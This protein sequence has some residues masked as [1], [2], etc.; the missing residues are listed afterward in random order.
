MPLEFFGDYLLLAFSADFMIAAAAGA[1]DVVAAD[2]L[3]F[4]DAGVLG[5]I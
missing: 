5:F 3:V 4:V 1:F 2:L